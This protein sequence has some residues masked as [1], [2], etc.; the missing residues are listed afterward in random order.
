MGG[1]LITLLVLAVAWHYER[2]PAVA[3]GVDPSACPFDL[4]SEAKD[5]NYYARWLMPNRCYDFAIGEDGFLGWA[6][7][8]GFA[9]VGTIE[10]P[11][12]I[13]CVKPAGPDGLEQDMHTIAH[14][15]CYDRMSSPDSGI[16]VAYDRQS[17]RA[18][19][20][21]HSR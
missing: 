20:H 17:R 8:R 13:M 3:F 16:H 21:Y 5:V 6:R 7:S 9:P 2:H 11:I 18:Y 12:Q 4:P 19:Y 10:R 15:Y 1:L 14:G